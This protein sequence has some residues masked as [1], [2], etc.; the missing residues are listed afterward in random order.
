VEVALTFTLAALVVCYLLARERF[1]R[2][3]SALAT[4]GV[5]LASPL[6]WNLA[7]WGDLSAAA[8][9]LF[10][11]VAA[12]AWIRISRDASG[13][14]R[15]R[16]AAAGLA[17][18]L[19]ATLQ[20]PGSP[21]RLL[22]G[23]A[24]DVLWSSRGGLFA[25]AP[26]LYLGALG[27]VALW[28]VDRALTATGLALLVLTTLV[29]GSV[30]FWWMTGRPSPPAFAAV[31][32]YLVCGAAAGVD[33]IAH[34]AARRPVLATSVLLSPLIVWNLALVQLAHEGVFRLGE[35][36][37]FGDIGA[38]QAERLHDW[39]G[40]P[41]SAP[42]SVAFAVAN[43]VRPG[44][45]DLLAPN[46]LLARGAVT[47]TL[48]IGT[49]DAPYVGDGWHAAERDGAVTFRWAMQVASIDLP[50]DHAADLRVQVDVR[51][52][53]PPN[54]PPQQLTLVVNGA[55]QA[56]V[57]LV[58]GWQPARMA[59]PRAA[60]RSGVNH[61]ELRF[62]YEARPSDAGIPDGR[63]FAASVDAILLTAGS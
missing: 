37:S 48:D 13:A 15:W 27:L 4:L 41:F 17:G 36:T 34:W 35:P 43:G 33:L 47:G 38:A 10:G 24:L 30:D 5:V 62:A 63:V 7:S 16:W 31:T 59:V 3:T 54:R 14:A 12:Y 2:A 25:T 50:L 56:P 46:R 61:L 51:P 22:D 45:Y 53:Q 21:A 8:R 58:S 55:P 52:Y 32:P 9:L 19:V 6:G 20:W 44:A 57:A 49:G 11:S 26:A 1:G 60:W 42:A 28:R 40:H 23:T 39:V 29:V 18:G